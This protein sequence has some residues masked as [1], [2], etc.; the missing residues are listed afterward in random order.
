M[1]KYDSENSFEDPF[2]FESRMWSIPD[3]L[4]GRNVTQIFLHDVVSFESELEQTATVPG[5]EKDLEKALVIA[6]PHDLVCVS[7]G[8][9]P[10]QMELLRNLGIGPASEKVIRLNEDAV[11]GRGVSYAK[12]LLGDLRQMDEICQKIPPTGSI[13]LNP[14]ISS[15]ECYQLAQELGSRIGRE[16]TVTGGAVDIVR[17]CIQKQLVNKKARDLDIPVASGETVELEITDEGIPSNLRPIEEAIRRQIKIGGAAIVKSAVAVLASKII[18]VRGE[19]DSIEAALH[20]IECNIGHSL[21]MVEVR[22]DVTVS[23]NI[24]F[25]VGPD[26]EAVRCVGI[27]D[28]RLSEQLAHQ[29]NIFPSRAQT[30][31]PMLKAAQR[32][33]EWLQAEAYCGIVGY[34]FCEHIDRQSGRPSFFLAEVNPRINGSVYPLSI[35]AHLAQSYRDCRKPSSPAFV[36]SKWLQIK[37]RSLEEMMEK[38]GHFFFSSGKTAGIIPYNTSSLDKGMVDV[39]AVGESMTEASDLFEKIRRAF[40]S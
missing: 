15:P 22:Y 19:Q 29:G 2:A 21:Y 36:S 39:V 23:P 20:Q 28:Q 4:G 33:S 18:Q 14:Y 16:V 13:V 12:A 31:G 6:R 10:A 8:T 24:L 26:G 11:S 5:R 3:T 35:L 40:V 32:F 34:D 38:F 7:F 30:L 25:Y 9:D 17:R 1:S 37:A 27:T